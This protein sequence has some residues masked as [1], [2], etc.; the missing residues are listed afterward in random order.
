MGKRIST[1]R[2]SVVEVLELDV[3]M[4]REGLDGMEGCFRHGMY[5]PSE[6]RDGRRRVLGKVM[7]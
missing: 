3:E 5:L 2:G 1:T 6:L 4:T 7:M